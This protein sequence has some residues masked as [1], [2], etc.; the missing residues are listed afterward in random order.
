MYDCKCVVVLQNPQ[1]Q[2]G[3]QS[4][5]ESRGV[6]GDRQ[7]GGAA[8]Q[9]AVSSTGEFQDDSKKGDVSSR[10]AAIRAKL[11]KNKATLSGQVENGDGDGKMVEPD[12][13]GPNVASDGSKEDL[14]AQNVR[15][16]IFIGTDADDV[17]Y[18]GED[19]ASMH[20]YDKGA[21]PKGTVNDDPEGQR[22]KIQALKREI[23]RAYDEMESLEAKHKIAI[24]ELQKHAEKECEEARVESERAAARASEAERNLEQVKRELEMAREQAKVDK[25]RMVEV[26]QS[27]QEHL[28]TSSGLRE[29]IARLQALIGDLKTEN[30]RLREK[31][32]DAPDDVDK[33]KEHDLEV[34]LMEARKE[35]SKSQS[36]QTFLREQLKKLKAQ[37]LGDQEEEEEKIRWRV[38]AEVKL[39]LERLGLGPD[40][41]KL[42][43]EDEKQ[44]MRDLEIAVQRADEAE[45]VASKWESIVAA[46]DAELGN[47]QRALG[48]LSYESDAAEQ[49]RAEVR[50]CQLKIHKLEDE[51]EKS[52]RLKEEAE[53]QAKAASELAAEERRRALAARESE[54]AAKQEMVSL[55]VAYND[56]ANKTS[57]LDGK[58]MYKREF[59]LELLKVMAGLRHS[60]AMRKAA[61]CVF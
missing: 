21:G 14:G 47:M 17:R 24:E 26:E 37:M 41:I 34:Q 56:L 8:E 36:E 60:Q 53:A 28:A 59:I 18:K 54:G 42:S 7:G 15:G 29:E 5:V 3:G 51:L 49:L 19:G 57:L 50:A 38:D 33:K 39:E 12:L 31:S 25:D 48:E 44:L 13:T 23:S 2:Q 22:N 35:M 61:E 55:Q 45:K 6:A 58:S 20:E 10:L 46:R 30:E 1:S 32:E 27:Q 11:E 4:V 9:G 52:K 16:D 43:R 40:G